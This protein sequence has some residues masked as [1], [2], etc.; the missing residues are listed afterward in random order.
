MSKRADKQDQTIDFEA[1]L[2]ELEALVEKMERGDLSLE[3]SLKDF[4]RGIALTRNC[5]QALRE[6]EQKVEILSGKGEAAE[7]AP[8]DGTADE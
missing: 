8:F 3:Q 2:Q 1:S 6:A 5:Q 7:L 4:E